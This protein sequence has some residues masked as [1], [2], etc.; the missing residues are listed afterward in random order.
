MGQAECQLRE[1][2]AAEVS[3]VSISDR[4]S[5]TV[6]EARELRRIQHDLAALM[7]DN[8]AVAQV[9]HRRSLLNP[10]RPDRHHPARHAGATRRLWSRK[11]SE[12]NAGPLTRC[13][14]YLVG[15]DE[16]ALRRRTVTSEQLRPQHIRDERR[17]AHKRPGLKLRQIDVNPRE[18]RRAG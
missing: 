4:H 16:R 3:R 11:H 9:E 7:H 5:R 2:A 6:L 8:R 1:D 14:Q 15:R 10:A 12:V 17:R 13:D 18:A